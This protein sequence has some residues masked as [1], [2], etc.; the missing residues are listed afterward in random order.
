MV[1]DCQ[2]APFRFCYEII[3]VWAK[4]ANSR[5]KCVA[6]NPLRSKALLFDLNSENATCL[7]DKGESIPAAVCL[8]V[9]N[10]KLESFCYPADVGRDLGIGIEDPLGK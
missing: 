1:N 3:K 9:R 5:L 4:V 8:Q 10:I 2:M 6:V 7:E